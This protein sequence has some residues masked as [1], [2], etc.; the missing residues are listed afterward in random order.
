MAY[1]I[2]NNL[3]PSSLYPLKATYPMT[4]E[5]ITIHNTANDATAINEIAYMTRN[6]D[7]I[8]YHVAID[9]KHVVQAIPFTRNGW[10]AGDGNGAGNRKSIG[11]EICYSKSGGTRYKAAEENAIEFIANLLQQFGWNMDRVKW[12]GDWSG[13][14]CPH[15]IMDEGRTLA[16][17][18]AIAKRLAE[19]N[20]NKPISP[21]EDV[22]MF[23]PSSTTLKAAFEQYLAEAV[24]EGVMTD[25]WLTDFKAGKLSLDDALALKV[26]IDQ[27]LKKG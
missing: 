15:R 21:K 22:R 8:S 19:L 13:K 24:K 9:D 12:H 26:I 23:N 14:N 11:I 4:P 10:H 18:N 2:I 20:T 7:A 5:Y 27:R 16:V 1:I 3:I 6:T 25:K 17:R